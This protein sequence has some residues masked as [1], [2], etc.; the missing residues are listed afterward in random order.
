MLK[1]LQMTF[2]ERLTAEIGK[3]GLSV[4]RLAALTDVTARTIARW[5]GDERVP[6]GHS[7]HALAQALN[8]TDQQLAAWK[9]DAATVA[10]PAPPQQEQTMPYNQI[11]ALFKQV[12]MEDR[13]PLLRWLGKYAEPD[14]QKNSASA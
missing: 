13:R 7:F 9:D 8:L 1:F 11:F 14:S 5:C 2:G 3:R 4:A 12:P 6:K 10:T